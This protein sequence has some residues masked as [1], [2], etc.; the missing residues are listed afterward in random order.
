MA[1]G[2]THDLVNLIALPGFLYF[3]PKELYIPFGAGY[4]V[5]T[6]FLSPDVDLPN[7]RPS[8]RWSFLRCLW[9]PYQSITQHRGVSHVPVI[10]SL[11]RLL[12]LVL[13]VSFI[14]FVVI[15]IV[16]VLDRGLAIALTGFNPFA[17]LNELFRSEESLFFVAGIICADVVHI[18]LDGISS[19]IKR[20][21]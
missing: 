17:Y 9:F 1:L 2:R 15:G 19:T 20:I 21:I 12:Y 10:G 14:Y 18:V 3:L 4:I 5:G 8:R 6:F 13:V 7:S 16:S 11:L